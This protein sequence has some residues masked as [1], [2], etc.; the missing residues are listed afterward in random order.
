MASTA[1]A[2]PLNGGEVQPTGA[3]PKRQAQDLQVDVAGTPDKP[4]AFAKEDEFSAFT[5]FGRTQEHLSA[6]ADAGKAQ[7]AGATSPTSGAPAAPAPAP[8]PQPAD[9]PSGK[10]WW[11]ALVCGCFAPPPAPVE[12]GS[13]QL[14]ARRTMTHSLVG[15]PP[16]TTM[17][18]RRTLSKQVS[19]YGGARRTLSAVKSTYSDDQWFDALS[20]ADPYSEAG[21]ALNAELEGMMRDMPTIGEAPPV[22]EP[23]PHVPDP[24]LEMANKDFIFVPVPKETGFAGYWLKDEERTTP[25]PQPI[26]LMLNSS[27]MAQKAHETIPGIWHA[28]GRT[29][30][31]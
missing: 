4:K 31:C 30:T 21:R 6:P 27:K 26:D 13:G 17:R 5:Q 15:V 24:P 12:T 20:V 3:A 29:S 18:P 22:Q 16:S 25:N 2:L 10:P 8:A 11:S 28:C 23:G 9:E 1:A 14:R 19:M 7:P